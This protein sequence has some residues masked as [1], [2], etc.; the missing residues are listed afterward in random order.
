MRHVMPLAIAGLCV[1]G[2]GGSAVAQNKPSL[3][4][5]PRPVSVAQLNNMNAF[6]GQLVSVSAVV[7]HSDTAQVFTFGDK[8]EPA[9]PTATAGVATAGE[10]KAGNRGREIHVVIPNPATDAAHVG[11]TVSITGFVRK[12]DAANFERDYKWF[13]RTDYPDVHG[14]DW[15]IVAVSVRTT[16]GTELVPPMTISDTPPAPPKTR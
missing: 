12:F 8:Q 10:N 2:F 9:S 5:K 3:D 14:G 11:D 16:E 4:P 1:F 6:D 13:R 15:V 7:R